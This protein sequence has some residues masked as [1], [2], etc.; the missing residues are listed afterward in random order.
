MTDTTERNWVAGNSM[1]G[2][3]SRLIDP[4][5][6]KAFREPLNMEAVFAIVV[7]YLTS[8]EKNDGSWFKRTLNDGQIELTGPGAA[9][10]L[11]LPVFDEVVQIISDHTGN[12]PSVL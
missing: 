1:L 5:P 9:I 2:F 10:R 12:L 7:Q 4:I 8:I 3:E 11:P 6:A